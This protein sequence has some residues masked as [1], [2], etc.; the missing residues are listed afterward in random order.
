MN[1]DSLRVG[2][3]FY[4]YINGDWLKDPN[5]EI[6][7]DYTSWG[8]FVKLYDQGLDR[9]IEIVKELES[10]DSKLLND[11]E[12]K[13][14]AIWKASQ[15]RFNKWAEDKSDYSPI[16]NEV[17]IMRGY[18]DDK[19]NQHKN[20][21]FRSLSIARYLFYTQTNGIKNVLDFDKGSN[22]L[23]KD[24]VVLDL[25]TSGLSLPTR[26]YYFIDKI[27][28]FREHLNNLTKIKELSDNLPNNFVED[29][30]SFETKMAYYTM[31]PDQ[32]REYDK[33][34]TNTTLEL[35]LTNLNSLNSLEKKRDN[36]LNDDKDCN[37]DQTMLTESN[38][39][40][41]ELY[42]LFNFKMRLR[43]NL[44]ENF[45][46]D[47]DSPDPEHITVFDGDGIRR[48]L[49]LILNNSL[50]SLK[51]YRAY[52]TYQIIKSYYNTCS[53]PLDDEFFNFYSKTLEGQ[54]KQKTNL[55]RSIGLVNNLAGE[56]LGKLYV[57]KYFSPKEK[58]NL[59]HSISK[60]LEIMTKSLENN[61]WLTNK[62]KIFALKKLSL[63]T[64]KIGYPEK[65]TDYSN[66]N[67]KIGDNLND[68]NK[69]AIRF[70]LH[71]N[72]YKKI[73]SCVDLDKWHMT[74]QTINAYYSPNLNEIVF[75]AAI[76]QP[77]FYFTKIEDIDFSLK[78]NTLG[79]SLT[80]LVANLGAIGAVI[81]HEI[82]HGFDDQGRKFCE[83][84][85]LK[86]WWCDEDI[87]LFEKKCEKVK[88]IVKKYY[89]QD[90]FG[91]KNLINP[92]LTM[93]ENIADLGG[94]SIS[95]KT[96]DNFLD[97]MK[98]NN[99][100][101]KK[102]AYQVFFKS[103]ANIWKTKITE[104]RRLMLLKCDPH[105]P[106]DFRGNLVKNFQQFHWSFNIKKGD[107]MYLEPS[108][109]LLMW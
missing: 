2:D 6:P 35:L 60:I 89:Y 54:K 102:N 38:L 99:E 91:V 69:E 34:Y 12:I 96:L 104:E 59:E 65:W 68:I 13:I 21:S 24:Q 87:N 16:I 71:E 37:L 4:Q 106:S 93:G 19:I 90:S 44:R 82:T 62:T 39:F 29:V 9:Q 26:D 105:S 50:Q 42:R 79:D 58:N 46:N 88:N 7:E 8:G 84:G 36:Y 57:K 20:T 11:D 23:N 94:L 22:L 75:P 66:F 108:E 109:R 33:Y 86:N 31:K 103:W 76:L 64:S 48:C 72:F 80:L 32:A 98:I 78:D 85:N 30:I 45:T 40:L 17:K 77:P 49:L 97:E 56:L 47:K 43:E 25:D 28:L 70:S 74:P 67:L 3:D 52:L 53:K 18:L 63:F 61:D 95:L 81:S 15:N 41:K 51:E 100:T 83:K 27:E 101:D 10:K 73:N 14:L 1:S 92:E 107:P 5:N 55:K